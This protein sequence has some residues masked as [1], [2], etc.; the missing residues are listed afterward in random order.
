MEEPKNIIDQENTQAMKPQSYRLILNEITSDES[1]P[2][3]NK[4]FETYKHTAF[5]FLNHKGKYLFEEH[6]LATYRSGMTLDRLFEQENGRFIQGCNRNK[7]G[8]IE[9]TWYD[10]L[11][12]E[13]I[14]FSDDLFDFFFAC[15]LRHLDLLDIEEFLSFHLEYSFKNNRPKFLSF[16]NLSISQYHERLFS[17]LIIEAIKEWIEAN[18]EA[19]NNTEQDG[20]IKGRIPREAGDRLTSINLHQTALLIQFM[21]QT[22]IILKGDYLTYL[23]AGKAFNILTG[24]SDNSL[25]QLLGTKGE[26]EGSKFE[27]YK[28]LHQILTSLAQLVETKIRKK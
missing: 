21:Q 10:T 3:F 6:I 24:Y 8:K 16:L 27:D 17:H 2:P 14:V 25:R 9:R 1:L 23:Q 13:E 15:K 5:M 19:K 22:G 28:E 26:I 18:N 11:S 12:C 20:K 4:D 7:A